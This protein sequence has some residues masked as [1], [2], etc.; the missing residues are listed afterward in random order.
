MPDAIKSLGKVDGE[1]ADIG[2]SGQHG[3]DGM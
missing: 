3:A 1:N 2:V